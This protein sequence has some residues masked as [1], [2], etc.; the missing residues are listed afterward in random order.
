MLDQV[1]VAV[2][3]PAQSLVLCVCVTC[4][5]ALTR[6]HFLFFF[7]RVRIKA[8]TSITYQSPPNDGCVCFFFGIKKF[9][10]DS[11]GESN[12]NKAS[13]HHGFETAYPEV[14]Q[15]SK[16]SLGEARGPP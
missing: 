11:V 8:G 10:D 4:A 1:G 7:L 13:N 3:H 14:S 16:R 12:K 5:V 9:D 2:G 15:C 6:V